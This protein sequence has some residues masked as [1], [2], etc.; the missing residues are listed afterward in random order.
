MTLSTPAVIAITLL[1]SASVGVSLLWL[2][3]WLYT[4]YY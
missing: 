4:R 1:V 3:K 2:L